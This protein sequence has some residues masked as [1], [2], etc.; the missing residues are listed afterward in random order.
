[1]PLWQV[2]CWG[3]FVLSPAV[4]LMSYHPWADGAW[5][6]YVQAVGFGIGLAAITWIVVRWQTWPGAVLPWIAAAGVLFFGDVVHYQRLSYGPEA[7]IERLVVDDFSA[8]ESDGRPSATRWLVDSESGSTVRVDGS[9]LVIQDAPGAIGYADLK[10]PAHP[11]AS[12]FGMT[13]PLGL[14]GTHFAEELE[15]DAVVQRE[16]DFLF[17][18]DANSVMIQ[19]ASYGIRLSYRDAE[20]RHSDLNLNTPLPNDGQPHRYRIERARDGGFR[21][22]IDGQLHFASRRGLPWQFMRF[23]ETRPDPLHGGTLRLD[24]VRYL[25]HYY[26]A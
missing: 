11:S 3:F 16:G 20:G 2:L 26:I 24:N 23:G 9:Q 19:A 21:F 1:V 10:L 4:R 18:F 15:W 13:R 14:Y 8:A 25:R 6:P 17:L 12:E 5:I 7:T 22:M